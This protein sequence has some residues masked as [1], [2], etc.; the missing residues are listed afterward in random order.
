MAS[1]IPVILCG[2]TQHIAKGV[3]AALRPEFEAIH[4]IL[5]PA[6]G[7]TQIPAL[8]RGE[9]PPSDDADN[10]GTRDYSKPP[11]AVILGAGYEDSH[12]AEMREL[13]KSD[14]K[15]P[16]LKPDL[17]KPAPPLGPDYG[18]AMVQRV[19]SRLAELSAGGQMNGD[20][21]YLF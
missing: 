14:S 15:I 18:K 2:R 9:V 7:K 1:P 11:A 4:L 6:T 19:K 12:V 10:I 5:S 8:L 17:S 13:C 20:G 21:V 16:W 3:I